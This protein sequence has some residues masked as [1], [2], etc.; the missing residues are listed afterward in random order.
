MRL[1]PLLTKPPGL[2]AIGAVALLLCGFVVGAYEDRL[3]RTER[4]AEAQVQARILAA[5]VAAPVL[6][7]DRDAAQEHVGALRANPGIRAAIVTDSAGTVL[8]AANAD[9]L[10]GFLDD[11]PGDAGARGISLDGGDLVVSEPVEDE[12]VQH[13]R[14][15]LRVLIEP[16]AHRLSRYARIALFAFT[17][18]L[19]VY[20]LGNAQRTL[21]RANRALEDKARD[22][23]EANRL[24][25]AQSVERARAE[26]A[27]RHAHKME[28]IGQLSG[29]IAHDFNNLLSIVRGNLE[30]I[31]KRIAQGNTDVARYLDFAAQGVERASNITQRILAFSR[32]QP[33]SPRPMDLNGV[34]RGMDEL[35][36]HSGSAAMRL[37]TRLGSTWWTLCDASQMENAILNLVI[38]ARDA[39]P[40]GGLVTLET[41]DLPAAAGAV[42]EGVPAVDYVRLAISDTGTG[43]TEEVLAKAIDPFF[44]TKPPGKGTGLGLSMIYG[45]VSQSGGRLLIDSHPGRGTVVTILMPRTETP[46]AAAVPAAAAAPPPLSGAARSPETMMPRVLIVEDEELLRMLAAEAFRDDGFEVIEE[47]D[48]REALDLI[49]AGTAFDLLVTDIRLPGLGGF[50]LTERALKLRPG[51]KVIMMTGFAQDPVPPV[52]VAAGVP[53]VYKPYN[54]KK[55]TQLA[56]QMLARPAAVN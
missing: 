28:A 6:F 52:L 25:H 5:G 12:G 18:A 22:L 11:L 39:M 46:A 45:F 15:Y 54:P 16:L 14:V 26:E 32:Q 8:A 10:T 17:A 37:E 31:R 20:V 43:M 27:L 49:Q 9:L 30:M 50:D 38:N 42:Y 33:L 7:G 19:M 4:V 1:G 51:L 21:T 2:A 3:Y 48:G 13:G 23:A 56:G 29:G 40:A 35:L 34:I 55:L 53:I 24:L 41:T 47:A 36:R 44:T